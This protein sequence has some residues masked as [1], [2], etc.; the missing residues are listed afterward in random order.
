MS[1]INYEQ[2]QLD[3]DLVAEYLTQ[4]PDFFNHY[5]HLARQLKIPHA[6]RGSVSLVELAQL[7]MRD[8]VASLEAEISDLMAVASHN[9]RI[10]RVYVELLPKLMHC[11]QL[12]ELELHLRDALMGQLGVSRISLK[13]NREYLPLSPALEEHSLAGEQIENLWVNRISLKG[14][15]F[16]RLTQGEQVLLFDNAHLVHSVAIMPLGDRARFGVLTAASRDADHYI[17]GMDSLLL[18]QLCEVIASLLPNLVGA[19]AA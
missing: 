2:I 5:P 14:H 17:A 19:D 12:A 15:Y 11:Q 7:R 18:G 4:N 16:G 3:D 1:Q 13:L 8:K 10:F 6:E 9:E